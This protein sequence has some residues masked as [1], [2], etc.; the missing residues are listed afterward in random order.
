[1]RDVWILG[2]PDSSN[3]TGM[4]TY[5]LARCTRYIQKMALLMLLQEDIYK[6]TTV[7]CTA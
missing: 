6:C 4:H 3:I 2:P 7:T 1:M 5:A